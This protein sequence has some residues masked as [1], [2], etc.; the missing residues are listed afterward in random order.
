METK[1]ENIQPPFKLLILD[2]FDAYHYADVV[3]GDWRYAWLTGGYAPISDHDKAI[4][5]ADR[6]F[7]ALNPEAKTQHDWYE[8]DAGYDVRVYDAD[9]GCVY[10]AHQKLPKE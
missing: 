5:L 7:W 8:W 2:L 9:N 6:L 1:T 10:K 4:A 3:S